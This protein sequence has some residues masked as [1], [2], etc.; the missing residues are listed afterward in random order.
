VLERLDSRPVDERSG[1]EQAF[2]LRE[3]LGLDYLCLRR[4]VDERHVDRFS[5]CMYSC[6]SRTHHLSSACGRAEG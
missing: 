5:I 2:D 3:D 1:V 6:G 4:E